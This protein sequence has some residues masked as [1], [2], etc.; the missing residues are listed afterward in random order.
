MKRGNFLKKIGIGMAALAV[1]PMI[2]AKA[3]ELKPR[4]THITIT[5]VGESNCLFTGGQY[6]RVLTQDE[7]NKFYDML[8]EPADIKY[9]LDHNIL[10]TRPVQFWIDG[11][12]VIK[13][14]IVIY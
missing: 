9:L 10:P 7:I 2:M 13:D 11:K 5:P 6:D 4:Y 14:S 1:A 12:Q 3:I 8:F